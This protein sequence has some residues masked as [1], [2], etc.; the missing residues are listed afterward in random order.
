MAAGPVACEVG[1]DFDDEALSEYFRPERCP[2]CGGL[3]TA[4]LYGLPTIAASEKYDAAV[5]AGHLQWGGCVLSPPFD[6]V[7]SCATCRRG[8]N[9]L[10]MAVHYVKSEMRE[11][12]WVPDSDED[13]A[14]W[15]ALRAE[16]DDALR[17]GRAEAA[18]AAEER[19]RTQM[20]QR[21]RTW[22]LIRRASLLASALGMVMVGVA[23]AGVLASGPPTVLGQDLLFGAGLL[24]AAVALSRLADRRAW[25]AGA[26]SA[27]A[28]CA[29]YAIFQVMAAAPTAADEQAHAHS[30]D[31]AQLVA[32]GSRWR[33]VPTWVL[34]VEGIWLSTLLIT[35]YQLR[36]GWVGERK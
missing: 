12:R 18:A 22:R 1:V 35:V 11:Y 15:D 31:R 17:R 16:R 32:T 21:R 28:A 24:L 25:V 9:D 8:I 30:V 7:S 27:V 6:V 14:V 3:R 33:L 36:R 4:I 2:H 20:G 26:A 10:G 19:R 34:W 13:R 5:Q 23:W 29:A